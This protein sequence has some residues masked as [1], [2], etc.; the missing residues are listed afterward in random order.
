L[1]NENKGAAVQEDGQ[2]MKELMNARLS[3][4]VRLYV[5]PR[6]NVLLLLLVVVVD[7]EKDIVNGLLL[8]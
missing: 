5:V 7:R 8:E 2:T 3:P 6:R 4:S 1:K